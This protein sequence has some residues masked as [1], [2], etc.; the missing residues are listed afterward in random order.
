MNNSRLNIRLRALRLGL[1]L[2]LG[3]ILLPMNSL[4]SVGPPGLVLNIYTEENQHQFPLGDSI[5][6]TLVIK[7]DTGEPALTER[8]FSKIELYTSLVVIDPAGNAYYLEKAA[9]GHIMPPPFFWKGEAW[10]PAEALPP[11]FVRSATITD[12]TEL[13]P[14]MKTLPGWY[15]L[16]PR[17]RRGGRP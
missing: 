1:C 6:L 10:S 4:S 3:M 16:D 14:V 5:K 7:N 9:L 8:E 12:I 17:I 11:D 15:T 13:V 2:C